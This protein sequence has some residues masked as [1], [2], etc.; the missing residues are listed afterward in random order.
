MGDELST[1]MKKYHGL[2]ATIPVLIENLSHAQIFLEEK[3]NQLCSDL[4]Q[5]SN[6]CDTF[7][8]LKHRE[9][10]ASLECHTNEYNI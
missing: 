6:K 2:L 10:S 3:Q 9:T 1:V 5:F 8:F 7:N 4:Q